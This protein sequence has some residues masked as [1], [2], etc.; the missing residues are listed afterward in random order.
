M[1][2]CAWDLEGPLSHVDFAAEI[3][4]L[5]EPKLKR[6]KLGDFFNMVSNYDDYLIDFPNVVKD[7][8]IES[9]EPGDTLRLLSPFY[10]WYFTD[11][12]LREISKK[13]PGLN[14]RIGFKPPLLAP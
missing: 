3:C 5:L 7:L 14:L 4:K 11:E 12:E 10:V 8:G 1:K 13:R 2:V 6:A 9:Y